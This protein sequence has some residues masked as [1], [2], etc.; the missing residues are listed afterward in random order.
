SD[1]FWQWV[2]FGADGTLFVSYYDRQYGTDEWTGFSD[3][4]VSSSIDLSHFSVTRAT[5][6]SMPPPT[7]FEG[8]FYGDYA[9]LPALDGAPPIWADTR[10]AEPFLCPG[11]GTKQQPPPLSTA[12]AS[13]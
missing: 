8:P 11:T 3:V 13:N 7:Q 5:S 6:T 4:S 1:Q 2:S 10:D 12:A 9:G